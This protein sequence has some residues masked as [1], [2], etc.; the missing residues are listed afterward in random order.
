MNVLKS[1]LLMAQFSASLVASIETNDF[2]PVL[3]GKGAAK[4]DDELPTLSVASENLISTK[5][6]WDAFTKAHPLFVV[7]AADSSCAACCDSEPLLND[8]RKTIVGKA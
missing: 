6:E 3:Y 4:C 5:A 7:G 1:A 8:L 2:E